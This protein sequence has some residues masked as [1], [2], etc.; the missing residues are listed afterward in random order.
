MA[1]QVSII[2]I[3]QVMLIAR[4]RLQFGNVGRVVR[5]GARITP[6]HCPV[7]SAVLVSRKYSANP[8]CNTGVGDV[9]GQLPESGIALGIRIHHVLLAV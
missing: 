8:A 7:K 1:R 9:P 4:N 2:E 5:A 6:G 3:G